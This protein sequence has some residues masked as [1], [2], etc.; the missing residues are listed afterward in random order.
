M[1]TPTDRVA[2]AVSG[3]KDSLSL[4][5]ILNKIEEKF[6][7]SELI[8]I[9]IDEGISNYRA[10]AIKL[11]DEHCQTLKIEHYTRSFKEVYGYD[12]D[13]IVKAAEARGKLTSCS[14]C[15]I[16]RRK[17][18]NFVAKEVNASKLA[19]GH[20]LD[21]EVQSMVMNLLR[22][23]IY[24]MRRI[25]SVLETKDNGFVEKVKPLCH[26][27]EKEVALYAYLKKIRFQT[28][29]CPYMETSMRSDIRRFL[30]SLEEKHAGIKFNIFQ[31]FKKI[32]DQ[33]GSE[34]RKNNINYCTICHEPT[35][36]KTCR[37]C[38]ILSSL[39]LKLQKPKLS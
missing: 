39:G 34:E 3:G 12:L 24:Q 33:L 7:K 1:F 14:Y 10:E 35:S 5:Y 36:G 21:D 25:G 8:A 4:L 16:L 38:N 28:I 17:A 29:S 19:T 18:L 11:A 22:G 15:G 9:T 13:E 27:P 26:L 30:N 23:D 20:N 37:A 6:P 31:T 32:K 2:V